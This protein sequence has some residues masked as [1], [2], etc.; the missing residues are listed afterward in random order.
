[1][2]APSGIEPVHGIAPATTAPDGRDHPPS[3]WA[4]AV[5]LL[6][7]GLLVAVQGN[8]FVPSNDEGLNVEGAERLLDGQRPYVDFFGHASPGAYL[9]Q[10][11][12]FR[13]GGRSLWTSRVLV[14]AYQSL[15]I[16]LLFWLV[17]RFASSKAAWCTI[18]IHTAIATADTLQLTAHHRWDSSTL[19]FLSIAMTLYGGG[20]WWWAGAGLVAAA[21]MV[22]TPTAGLIVLVTL[23]WLVLTKRYANAAQYVG[24]VASGVVPV[25]LWMAWQGLLTSGRF[26]GYLG[27]L[28]FMKANYAEANATPYGYLGSGWLN[29]LDLSDPNFL[30][31]LVRVPIVL[32]LALPAI[33]PIAA[34]ACWT[35][36]IW[37]SPGDL[38]VPGNTAWFLIACQLA[39]LGYS[40]PRIDVS[41]LAYTSAFSVA[42]VAI[43]V[44]CKMPPKLS[45][46][47][48]MFFVF[49]SLA[50]VY[51]RANIV[52]NARPY[53]TPVG[54]VMVAAAHQSDVKI[55]LAAVRPGD[56]MFAYPF[57]PTLGFLTQARNPTSFMF[58][59]P[60]M[61]K[62]SEEQALLD[63]LKRTMPKW[64]LWFR[65]TREQFLQAFPGAGNLAY[66]YPRT[67]AWIEENYHLKSKLPALTYD[68]WERQ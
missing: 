51:Q 27:F 3:L 38:P 26:G 65:S 17:A 33:A 16:A 13:I 22:A 18:W 5:F 59:Q 64:I 55:L 68:L 23:G 43:W 42:L 66:H 52:I 19:G 7:F 40:Y 29:L 12:V 60:G 8:L 63:D 49:W 48:A 25:L 41:H 56:T 45:P 31:L 37:R 20:S 36:W 47:V 35:F 39:M 4:V 10:A 44:A 34:L 61:M 1:M 67:E 30:G 58:I 21:A 62:D 2:T 54:P 11:V 28:A 9:Y 14:L 32:C 50:F 24:G 57:M 53:D 46:A 15:Q 6:V